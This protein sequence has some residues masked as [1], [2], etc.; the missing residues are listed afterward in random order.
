MDVLWSVLTFF[1]S[2]VCHQL[3]ERSY[4]W[5]DL[6][7]PLCARCIGIHFGFLVSALF[8]SLGT[9]RYCSLVLRPSHLI[10]L[11]LVMSF[12]VLD[13][14]ISYLGIS[15]SDNLRR[16]LSGLSF[17]IPLPFLLFPL[18]NSFVFAKRNEVRPIETKAD[19][20][21]LPVLYL[22]SASAVLLADTNGI[23]FGAVSVLGIIGVFTFFT[24]NASM[25]ALL[26]FDRSRISPCRRLA[27]G[28]V[29]VVGVLLVIAGVRQSFFE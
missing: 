25:L 4:F 20:L 11:G 13:T 5:G 26:G 14:S 17:G 16:T 23:L 8:L 1:G 19:W 27:I 10:V 21:A 15:Q 18:I 12:F 22:L 2:A 24:M 7:M 28:A 29:L 6:Q 9:K 3:P